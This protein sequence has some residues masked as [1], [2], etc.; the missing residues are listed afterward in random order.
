MS[1]EFSAAQPARASEPDDLEDIVVE[2]AMIAQALGGWRG[3]FD[4]G[5]PSLVFVIVYLATGQSLTPSL[6]AAVGVGLVVVVVRLARRQ[7]I[8]Q[9]ASGFFGL[10]FSAWLA[11]RSGKA[12]DFFLPG[13]LINGVYAVVL[14]I[15]ILIRR[16]LMAYAMGAITGDVRGWM[17]NP[18]RRRAA[19][20]ATWVW[21]VLFAGKLAVQI[22][23]YL[24]GAVAALG[25]TRVV[26]GYPLLALGAY[27]SF[28]HIQPAQHVSP[29]DEGAPETD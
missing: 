22:P 26:L 25:I 18:Q 6:W 11:S 1:E 9:V 12:E 14:F 10:A 29:A 19:T 7:S 3:V 24:A 15:S 8:Q 21:V 13:L 4:S 5:I 23:L 17:T 16:P 20:A 27:L 28:R 2:K